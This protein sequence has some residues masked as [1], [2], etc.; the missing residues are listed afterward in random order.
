MLQLK[1]SPKYG[2]CDLKD[3]ADVNVDFCESEGG[4]AKDILPDS[5][6]GRDPYHFMQNPQRWAKKNGVYEALTRLVLHLQSLLYA[7]SPED[8]ETA[9]SWMM[10]RYEG[11]A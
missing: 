11:S 3:P 4:A 8:F 5:R 2:G 10:E 9:L 6:L 7:R 1:A